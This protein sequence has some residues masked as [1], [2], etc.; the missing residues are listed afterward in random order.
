MVEAP[1]RYALVALGSAAL[2]GISTPLAKLLIGDIEPL[3]LAG[4]LYAGSG[5][6]LALFSLM[7]SSDLHRR[8]ATLRRAELGW[9]ACSVA[10]GGIVA[11]VLLMWGLSRLPAAE[12]SLLLNFE[13]VLTVLL[14]AVFFGEHVSRRVWM[15]TAAMFVA[16]LALAW[17]PGEAL[18][19]SP[20]ALAVIGA[21]LAWALDNNATR[22]IAS[23]DPV[24]LATVKGL[25]AGAANVA[26]AVAYGAAAPSGPMV[27]G[28]LVLGAL[29]YGAS[30]VLYIVA[31]R[32]LGTARTGAH[33]ATAP[34]LG[35][36]FALLALGEPVQAM[37]VPAVVVMALAT[38]LLVTERHSH[39]HTH[40]RMEHDHE[41][42]H[43]EHHRHAHAAGQRGEPHSHRHTH[44]PMT[45]SH[46]HLPDLHHRHP[47]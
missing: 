33:F 43:D 11:P 1:Q 42:V 40:E 14:A 24:T 13:A 28:A 17:S 6:G 34:F 3:L 16:G 44:E 21:C 12:T 39:R 36:A 8:L 18:E 15:A 19:L 7:R 22:N 9:L 25:V 41:H 20:S 4:L 10:S 27:T 26:L 47:H 45:H 29:S 38:A 46:P 35:A 37:F 31:L 32:H 2:F 5:L 23:A 30:L